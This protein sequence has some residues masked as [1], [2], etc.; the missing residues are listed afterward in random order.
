MDTYGQRLEATAGRDGKSHKKKPSA[1][2][3]GTP[4]T[5][6]GD[7]KPKFVSFT[8]HNGDISIHR[9]AFVVLLFVAKTVPIKETNHFAV[10]SNDM[11]QS[12]L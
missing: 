1:S 8:S 12:K 5:E 7:R 2:H 10:R 9:A 4:C 3:L 6:D 11:A